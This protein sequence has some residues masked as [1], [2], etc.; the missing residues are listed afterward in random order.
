QEKPLPSVDPEALRERRQ[1][2]ISGPE[3]YALFAE[4]GFQYGSRFQRIVS[5]RRGFREVVADINAGDGSETDEY[6]V[7]PTV[8]DACF[9]AIIAI[10][11]FGGESPAYMPVGIDRLRVFQRPTGILHCH[12]RLVSRSEREMKSN[13]V[14]FDAQ[15]NIVLEVDGFL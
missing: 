8:L 2:E 13:L 10:N 7:H 14:M 1:E 4:Q 15:G 12:A 3:C 5:M 6:R 11:P 9:Q